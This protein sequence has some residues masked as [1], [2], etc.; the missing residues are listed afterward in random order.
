MA[1]FQ[2]AF[3]AIDT[4]NH[5]FITID[6]LRDYMQR[7]HYK[8]SF[9]T[10]WIGLFDP[11]GS[12]RITYKQYCD[13]LGLKRSESQPSS[14][15]VQTSSPVQFSAEFSSTSQVKPSAAEEIGDLKDITKEPHRLP[16]YS[17]SDEAIKGIE[18]TIQPVM[19][20]SQSSEPNG[21]SAGRPTRTGKGKK[22][23]NSKSGS[24]KNSISERRT[25]DSSPG[26]IAMDVIEP[27]QT[28]PTHAEPI[29]GQQE[30]RPHKK[31]GGSSDQSNATSEAT[32]VSEREVPIEQQKAAVAQKSK[33]PRKQG[34]TTPR[35]SS[36]VD[37]AHIASE[38]PGPTEIQCKSSGDTGKPSQSN[39]RTHFLSES[40]TP[41]SSVQAKPRVFKRTH[42]TY[43]RKRNSQSESKAFPPGCLYGDS[44]EQS[45]HLS[46]VPGS[47]GKPQKPFF[48]QRQPDRFRTSKSETDNP[49]EVV[50]MTQW[51]R[52]G[53]G[54]W[55]KKSH[56]L[57]RRDRN[58]LTQPKS[59][60][61]CADGSPSK[62]EPTNFSLNIGDKIEGTGIYVM[63]PTQVTDQLDGRP[64]EE[65]VE[66]I[67]QKAGPKVAT[68]AA[69]GDTES[70]EEMEMADP[71]HEDEQLVNQ[72][73]VENAI[74]P[75]VFT[76]TQQ[77]ASA[78]PHESL[79]EEKRDVMDASAMDYQL[80][81]QLAPE[82]SPQNVPSPA[83]ATNLIMPEESEHI[84][85][86][87]QKDVE[88]Q[89]KLQDREWDASKKSE[90]I[91]EPQEQKSP[92]VAEFVETNNGKKAKK[93]GR[94]RKGNS[95]S[96]VESAT[97]TTLLEGKVESSPIVMEEP[98]SA[99]PPRG[100]RQK[101]G[102]E[103]TS[104]S[105]V[106][107]DECKQ[108]EEI[109]PDEESKVVD[110]FHEEGPA[111]DQLIV[112]NK[113]QPVFSAQ[114][115]QAAPVRSTQ[116]QDVSSSSEEEMEMA[117]PFHE[118]FQPADD[119]AVEEPLLTTAQSPPNLEATNQVG[120]PVVD[121]RNEPQ[122]E[123]EQIIKSADN[124][125]EK[126][127]QKSQSAS[128]SER[129][130][131]KDQEKDVE[132]S[133]V[134]VIPTETALPMEPTSENSETGE[135]TGKRKQKDEK[136][137]TVKEPKS[138]RKVKPKI[139]A[140]E[141]AK[142]EEGD[143]GAG[144]AETDIQAELVLSEQVN[145]VESGSLAVP[146]AEEKVT[147]KPTTSLSEI[148]DK[149]E[150]VVEITTQKEDTS[151]ARQK[152]TGKTAQ[153]HLHHQQKKKKQP[154][155]L[156]SQSPRVDLQV[157]AVA[158]KPSTMTANKGPT[159]RSKKQPKEVDASQLKPVED[160]T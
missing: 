32:L 53:K 101:K 92:R 3:N 141:Q 139:E 111:E 80:D 70:E 56:G 135:S 115:L 159:K 12:G 25:S 117:D 77:L 22:Q 54:D 106:T 51:V 98:S 109:P 116:N 79:V 42:V 148:A 131:P 1:G 132:G 43:Q 15:G 38:H 30:P 13:T 44:S 2:K 122:V 144:R 103:G 57:N 100:K 105:S 34:K 60:E 143:N 102:S 107:H 4:E 127:R 69:N 86:L 99:L 78:P 90:C 133:V 52:S 41:D 61:M 158:S 123:E 40:L 49:A 68:Y 97:S 50:D 62:I 59:T 45:P 157:Q 140:S 27:I 23:R 137:R 11:E 136:P 154:E 96:S 58:R 29:R 114:I 63:T 73:P 126:H 155:N 74:Q 130:S 129:K 94:N 134:A 93:N 26:T 128:E 37:E 24:H 39:K 145:S 125:K 156:P 150:E 113:I 66:S 18:T 83:L 46:S 5:G 138:D 16:T 47:P 82:E 118:D 149:L 121:S 85:E 10:K 67:T 146:A 104:E 28:E 91:E 88:S 124:R 151:A 14:P 110:P 108:Q 95:S 76:E 120:Q 84:V 119:A 65:G 21:M 48:R 71:F 87:C 7:M 64:V 17:G 36:T 20:G 72:L 142:K 75:V 112:E 6:E 8:E 31:R 147:R 89:E 55:P 152:S 19:A 35:S 153:H 160:E 81:A 9:V 33:H